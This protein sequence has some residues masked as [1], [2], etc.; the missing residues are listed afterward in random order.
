MDG[1]M[2]NILLAKGYFY[3]SIFTQFSIG[4]TNKKTTFSIG[5][6]SIGHFPLKKAFV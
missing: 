6:S 5:F 1:R 2:A 3:P 4:S